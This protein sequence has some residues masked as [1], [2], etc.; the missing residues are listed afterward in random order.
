MEPLGKPLDLQAWV[1]TV[2]KG[3]RAYL[4]VKPLASTAL[5]Y[6]RGLNNYLYYFGGS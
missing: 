2:I 3:P 6:Y 4:V 5:A 1:R